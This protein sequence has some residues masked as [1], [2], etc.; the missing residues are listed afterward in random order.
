MELHADNYGRQNKNKLVAYLYWRFIVGLY[1][2]IVN[3]FMPTGHT[4]CQGDGF[5]DLV[6]QKY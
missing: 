4:R 3:M 6:K 2:E 1:K 5:F